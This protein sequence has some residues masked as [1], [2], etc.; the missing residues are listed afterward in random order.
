MS[1]KR[2]ILN[3]TKQNYNFFES[4]GNNN[5]S[6]FQYAE[7]LLNI[8]LAKGHWLNMPDTIDTR[9]LELGLALNGSMVGFKDDVIGI[10]CLPFAQQGTLD[11]YQVPTGR[12]AYADNGYHA[13][14]TNENSVICWNNLT[15]TPSMPIIQY[16]A[17]RLYDLDCTIDVNAKAQKTP[18]LILCDENQRLSLKNV[19]MQYTGNQPVIYG[20]KSLLDNANFQVLNTQAPYVGDKLYTLKTQIWN[21]AV[22]RFGTF[23]NP[24]TKKERLTNVEIAHSSGITYAMAESL[25]LARQQFCKELNAMFGLHTWYEPATPKEFAELA[26]VETNKDGE[27]NE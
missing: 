16:Y 17:K 14:L 7:A 25:T 13:S 22:S 4:L 2:N 26:G 8:C 23:N 18:I 1:R 3:T 15:R 20:S 12:Y 24:E 27:I 11:V 21:D 10:L 6:H 19:Y 9:F 5:L